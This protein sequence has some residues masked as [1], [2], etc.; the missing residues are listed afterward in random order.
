M[1]WQEGTSKGLLG[2]IALRVS[3]QRQ[4][5]PNS[6]A[7]ILPGLDMLLPPDTNYQTHRPQPCQELTGTRFPE[8]T[9]PGSA[10]LLGVLLLPLMEETAF[11]GRII[12]SSIPMKRAQEVLV[13]LKGT[14]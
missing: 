1:G 12:K 7:Y 5:K 6:A 14:L 4:Y 3:D 8:V 13:D 2:G 11:G 9:V 10:Q